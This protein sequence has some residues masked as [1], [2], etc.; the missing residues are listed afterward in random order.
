MRIGYLDLTFADDC[1]SVV[2]DGV[3]LDGFKPK[4]V[5]KIRP[6]GTAREETDLDIGALA[7]IKIP[8]HTAYI[9][10]GTGSSYF[11]PEYKVLRL[12]R[13]LDGPRSWEAKEVIAFKT[14]RRRSPWR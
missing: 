1:R 11:P 10:R 13:R 6:A 4:E 9:S 7:V 3:H 5:I 12:E 14:P 2:L 8:G